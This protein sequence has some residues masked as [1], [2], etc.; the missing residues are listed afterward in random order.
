MKDKAESF[1]VIYGN[2]IYTVN[3]VFMHVDDKRRGFYKSKVNTYPQFRDL[4]LSLPNDGLVVIKN[5]QGVSMTVKPDIQTP[6]VTNVSKPVKV[7]NVVENN[8]SN[9]VGA[10]AVGTVVGS[11]LF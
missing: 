3:D 11:L 9:E 10:F 8:S 2:M 6:N 5:G 4:V 7:N 1:T